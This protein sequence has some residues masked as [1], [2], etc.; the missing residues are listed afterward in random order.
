[1]NKKITI[2]V[3]ALILIT[4]S[5]LSGC[6]D[7]TREPN[8]ANTD[9]A[10][11]V[12]DDTLTITDAYGRTVSVPTDVQRTICVGAGCLRYLCYLGEQDTVVGVEDIE[13]RE[14]DAHPRPY[15]LANPQFGDKQKYPYIGAF[16]GN[17]DAESILS[18]DPAPQVIFLTYS[19]AEGAD[20]LSTD[21]GGI[22]VVGLEYGDTAKNFYDMKEALRLMG[23]VTDRSKRVE[24]VMRFIEDEIKEIDYRTQSEDSANLYIGG[25]ASRGSH[26]ILSTQPDYP[27]F[28]Y[29]NANNIASGTSKTGDWEGYQIGDDALLQWDM[30]PG[31]DYVFLDLSI[32]DFSETGNSN[33][34]EKYGVESL[35]EGGVYGGLEAAQNKQVYGVLPYNWYTTNHG[36]VLADAWY[37]AKQLYPEKF[38]DIDPEDK[39]NEIY[40]FLYSGCPVNESIYE[41]VTESFGHGFGPIELE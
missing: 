4:T 25:T 18:L 35:C 38:S 40:G 13:Q 6:V 15:R 34:N 9:D 23:T 28:G 30:E 17:Y 14:E 21:V 39:S 3:V 20:K 7:N 29:V 16:R 22:P 5:A 37:V 19:T 2:I 10:Q 36:N 8:G 31:I 11:V 32:Y 12:S 27:P 24:D 41:G 33:T 1:M 26:G